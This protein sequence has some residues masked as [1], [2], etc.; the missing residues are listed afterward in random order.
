MR[1]QAPAKMPESCSSCG[2]ARA[3]RICKNCGLRD[4]AMECEHFGT[5]LVQFEAQSGVMLCDTCAAQRRQGDQD[6]QA[7][8]WA[9]RVGG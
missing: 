7:A 3:E 4:Q 9:E 8:A 1:N 6:A 5:P 2:A